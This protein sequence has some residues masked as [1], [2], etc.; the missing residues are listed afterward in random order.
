MTKAKHTKETAP[1]HEPKLDPA[2]VHVVT[3]EIARMVNAPSAPPAPSPPVQDIELA[4]EPTEENLYG[5]VIAT[6]KSGHLAADPSG[7]LSV[8][9]DEN[10][11]TGDADTNALAISLNTVGGKVA[12]YRALGW[13]MEPVSSAVRVRA[14]DLANIFEVVAGSDEAPAQFVR[15]AKELVEHWLRA[16]A[17]RAMSW[18]SV[19]EGIFACPLLAKDG[20]RAAYALDTLAASVSDVPRAF[21]ERKAEHMRVAERV[22]ARIRVTHGG[23]GGQ[24]AESPQRA[25]AGLRRAAKSRELGRPVVTARDTLTPW[26]AVIE[27]AKAFGVTNVPKKKNATR[28]TKR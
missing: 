26:G 5:D 18:V 25:E 22:I 7:H 10:G 21:V 11:G 27:F 16:T 23:A 6:A 20:E 15:I 24:R 3:G 12:A 17:P 2:R 8:L 28:P 13:A 1:R 4:P 9:I 19:L 14:R